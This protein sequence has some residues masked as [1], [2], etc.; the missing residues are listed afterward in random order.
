MAGRAV[1]NREGSLRGRLTPLWSGALPVD[2]KIIIPVST[3]DD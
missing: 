2:H 1:T 3:G